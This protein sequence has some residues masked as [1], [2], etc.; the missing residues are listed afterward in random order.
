MY[1]ASGQCGA[2]PGLRKKGLLQRQSQSETIEA[3]A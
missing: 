3:G 2:G 1:E